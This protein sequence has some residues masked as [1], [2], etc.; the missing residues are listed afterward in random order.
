MRKLTFL[1]VISCLLLTGCG[2]KPKSDDAIAEDIKNEDR[3][4]SKYN[5][6]LDSFNVDKRQTN[7]EQ[8]T[9]YVWLT[10]TG[11]NDEFTYTASYQATYVLYNDGW[12]LED[13]DVTEYAYLATADVD[14]DQIITE[15][16]QEYSNVNLTSDY[17]V[18]NNASL[19]FSAEKYDTHLTTYYDI[20]IDL[21]YSPSTSW[22][23][24]GFESSITKEE[25]N[26]I[27]EWIYSDEEGRYYYLH[28][29]DVDEFT[30]TVDYI[31]L[32]TNFQDEWNYL[33]S[34]GYQTIEMQYIYSKFLGVSD[35]TLYFPFDPSYTGSMVTGDINIVALL[36]EETQMTNGE[37]NSGFYVNHV[38]LE[39]QNDSSTPIIGKTIAEEKAQSMVNANKEPE[40]NSD[41]G[42]IIG[43]LNK[44]DISEATQYID[45]LEQKTDEV[46]VIEQQIS[47]FTGEYG[48]CLGS[49]AENKDGTGD[50][51]TIRCR[52]D[53]DLILC[54]EMGSTATGEP[55]LFDFNGINE[56]Y[57]YIFHSDRFDPKVYYLIE[58]TWENNL[59][60]RWIGESVDNMLGVTYY[61]C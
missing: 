46:L 38:F 5:L 23:Q 7:E 41:V 19:T 14:V 9:D 57:Y 25:L 56:D 4:F 36:L 16:S 2:N 55:K 22:E 47:V 48:D 20:D 42:I 43:L 50:V 3:Y 31:F 35:D 12:L 44:G 33:S 6:E 39:K 53:S 40:D 29:S 30:V 45:S 32:N 26:V 17:C 58:F 21:E 60:Y 1:L 13:A 11:S 37:R 27:G 61:P 10:I 18:G 15:L 8:K 51:I 59:E 52:Y 28:V 24:T 54:A 49:W 34:D